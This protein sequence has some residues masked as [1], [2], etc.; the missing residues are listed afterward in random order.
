MACE[1]PIFPLSKSRSGGWPGHPPLLSEEKKL[2]LDRG[3]AILTFSLM[4]RQLQ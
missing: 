4:I 2:V 1:D 3:A